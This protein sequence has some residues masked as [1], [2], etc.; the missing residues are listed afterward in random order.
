MDYKDNGGEGVTSEG[1]SSTANTSAN[2]AEAGDPGKFKLV[3]YKAPQLPKHSSKSK[4]HPRQQLAIHLTEV[5]WT[6]LVFR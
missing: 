2:T 5:S 3:H 6:S 1:D 4:R